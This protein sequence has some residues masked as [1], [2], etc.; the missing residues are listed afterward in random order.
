M[1]GLKE[2]RY[3]D[4]FG[5]NFDEIKLL[6]EE[7]RKAHLD[8]LSST[9]D[10]RESASARFFSAKSTSQR[11]IRQIK[12]NWWLNLTHEIQEA[13][14]KKDTKAFYGLLRQAYGPKSSSVS[15]LLAKDG[16]TLLKSPDQIKDRWYE[17]FRDLFHNPSTVNMDAVDS[18][19]QRDV[20]Q[21]IDTEPTIEETLHA[22]KQINSR[23]APGLDGIPVEILKSGGSNLQTAIHGFMK[24]A[25]KADPVSQDWI[26]VI[27][28]MLYKGKGKKSVCSSYRGIS[29]LESVGKVFARLLLN[30]LEKYICP[31]VIPETQSGFRG[32]RGTV[33]MI[34]SAR[35]LVEKSMEQQVPLC[36]A[37]V[38]L[39]KAFDTVNREALWKVLGKYGCPQSFVDKFEK[40]H[41]GMKGRVN[42]NG[43]L[44]EELP[45]DNGVKQGDIPAPTLFSLYLTAV[46]WYTFHDCDEAVYIR[47]RTTGKVFNLRRFQAKSLTHES[48]VRELLYADDADL[49]THSPEGLQVVMDRFSNACTAFGLTISTDKTKIMYTSVPGEPPITKDIFVYGKRLEIVKSFVYLGSKLADDGSLDPEIEQRISKASSAFGSLE[50][51]VWSD[52]DLTITTKLSVYKTCV[53]SA[54]LYASEAWTLYQPK[55]KSLERFHQSCLRRVLGVKWWHRKSD[56]EILAKSG[57]SS[58]TTLIMENQLRWAGHLVRLEDSRLPKQFLFSELA[59][60]SRPQWKPKKRWRDSLK[61]TLKAF[62][63]SVDDWEVLATDRNGW[64][65][66]IKDGAKKFEQLKIERLELKRACRK[67]VYHPAIDEVAFSCTVCNRKLLSKAGLVNHVKSHDNNAF[68]TAYESLQPQVSD[69]LQSLTCPQCS[70]TCKSSGGLKRHLKVNE[71]DPSCSMPRVQPPNT[72]NNCPKSQKKMNSLAGQKSHLRWHQRADRVAIV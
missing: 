26:D 35:Q 3:R 50:E 63:I 5:D 36:Q 28:I 46:L 48:V 52:G 68:Q 37:F 66:L 72:D 34:F 71:R 45:I 19:P 4:W 59:I 70:K 62:G 7:K 64:R 21:D 57:F 29:L 6:I 25:W 38:D 33:D 58:L 13:F 56:T 11:R 32:G 15:P 14:N 23:K 41:T 27:L 30:R 2:T 24:S 10:S 60:G 9:P 67:Q 12:N 43:Q 16:I 31:D 54:L 44:T 65:K 69:E 42:F 40:L 17:H 8:L 18:L 49:V 39:T 53:L 55:M 20:C 22:I 1:L 47:F 61:E 51:R